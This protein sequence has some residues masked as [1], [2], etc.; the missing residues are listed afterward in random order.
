MDSAKQN[1]TKKKK[2]KKKK[3]TKK[4]DGISAD[5]KE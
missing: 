4:K 5:K 1:G 3:K 2:K